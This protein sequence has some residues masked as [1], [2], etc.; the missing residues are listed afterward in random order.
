M[1]T[2]VRECDRAQEIT[3]WLGEAVKTTQSLGLQP[4]LSSSAQNCP[5]CSAALSG[6]N[7]LTLVLLMVQEELTS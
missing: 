6:R 5:Y 4:A 3:C 7:A 2:R 1:A